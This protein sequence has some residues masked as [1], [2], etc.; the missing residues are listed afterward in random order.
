MTWKD[1]MRKKKSRNKG[2]FNLRNRD[3]DPKIKD[4]MD[5]DKTEREIKMTISD[6]R[7]I[8]ERKITEEEG[9]REKKEKGPEEN[10]INFLKNLKVFIF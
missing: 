2:R 1:W 8:L 6:K 7:S 10:L 5:E 9:I 3:T 4:K